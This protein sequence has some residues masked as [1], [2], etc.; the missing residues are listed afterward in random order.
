MAIPDFQTLM[1]P[2]LCVLEDGKEH[3]ARDVIDYLADQFSLTSDERNA[4]SPSG[5]SRTFYT[6]VTWAQSYMIQAG[7]VERTRRGDGKIT[8]KGLQELN[9]RPEKID[10]KYLMRFPEFQEFRKVEKKA[11]QS[12]PIE[13]SSGN[14]PEE[15]LELGFQKITKSLSSELLDLI[16]SCTPEFFE[17]LVVQLLLKMGYGGSREDAGRRI[18]GSG[19]GGVDGIINEDKL[20]L[21]VIYIQAKK[22]ENVVGR[23]EIQKFVGALQGKRAKKGVFITTSFFSPEARAYVEN[24]E[25]RVVLIDGEQ[26]AQFMIDHN[27]GVSTFETYEI[28]KI[29]SDFFSEE[30]Y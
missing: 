2:V 23:P 21:D 8:E 7:L 11:D 5:K 29:D 22:W 12:E 4:L 14:T 16:K 24:I 17:R 28:K 19:D 3:R 13:Q 9:F 15:L 20:G 30:Q 27:V 25:N 6:R 10:I 1:L 26:L 18:G